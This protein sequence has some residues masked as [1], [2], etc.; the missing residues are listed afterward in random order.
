MRTHTS[1][2]A[3]LAAQMLADYEGR[4]LLAPSDPPGLPR[5]VLEHLAVPVL[6]LAGEFD[7]PWRRACAAALGRIAPRG[8]HAG[9]AAAGHLANCDNPEAFDALAGEFLRKCSD[10]TKKA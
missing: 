7:T 5:E 4:D 2:A 3:V 9:I 6:A 10:P 1:E 8:R